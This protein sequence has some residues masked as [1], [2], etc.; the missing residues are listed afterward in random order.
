MYMHTQK[1]NKLIKEFITLN[2]PK[3]EFVHGGGGGM[4]F[5]KNIYSVDRN[6]P[7]ATD[8][9]MVGWDR[10]YGKFWRLVWFFMACWI[11]LGGLVLFMVRSVL[12]M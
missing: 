12:G 7:N 6:H 8:E 9:F 1:H 10:A 3:G 2:D 5:N 11:L 4:Y